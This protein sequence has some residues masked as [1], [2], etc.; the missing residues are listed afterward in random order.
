M[1]IP[2]VT[3]KEF[4]KEVLR[5]SVPVLVVFVAKWSAPCKALDPVLEAYALEVEG[6]A[7]VVKVD[8]DAAPRLADMLRVQNL[9]TLFVFVQG[10]PANAV[11]GASKREQLAALLDP[12]LPRPEGAIKPRELAQLLKEKQVVAVDTREANAFGRAHVPGAINMP[13]EEIEGRLAELHML[14]A[15][16]VLYCRSGDRSKDL[17]DKL[18]AQG[19]P[20]GFLEGGFLLWEAEQLPIERPD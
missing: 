11:Q 17:A 1:P 4:E 13:L 5:A 8:S 9:P 7:K 14:G 18:S 10:R 2:F 16:P 6:K 20:V 3:E 19:V 15:E 12:F